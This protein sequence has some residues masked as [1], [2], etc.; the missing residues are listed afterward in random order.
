[1]NE[2]GTGHQNPTGQPGTQEHDWAQPGW[3]GAEYPPQWAPPVQRTSG[4]SIAVLVLGIASLTVFWG[5]P[6]IVALFLAP[7]AKREI[8][9]SQG[10]LGG[11]GMV[12]AGVICSWISIGLTLLV[13]TLVVGVFTMATLAG[14]E[15]ANEVITTTVPFE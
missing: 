9:A 7:R 15:G 8:A 11:A 1:M 2:Q 5:I 10:G 6:G 14:G 3:S 13:L 4:N 12:R